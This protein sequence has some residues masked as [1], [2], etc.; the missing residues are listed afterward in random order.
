MK[1]S[2]HLKKII[3]LLVSL[4]IVLWI[5]IIQIK[6]NYRWGLSQA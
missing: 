3:T 6:L 4:W 1:L 5:I 2:Q